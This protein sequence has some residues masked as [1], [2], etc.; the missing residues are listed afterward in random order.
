MYLLVY[1][2]EYCLIKEPCGRGK[3]QSDQICDN[4]ATTY[5][6]NIGYYEKSFSNSDA[7][8][9]YIVEGPKEKQ[10]LLRSGPKYNSVMLQKRRKR[11]NEWGDR[12]EV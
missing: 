6:S 4:H 1:V 3:I 8:A 9:F 12:G 10:R 11:K 7:I 2:F 5:Y